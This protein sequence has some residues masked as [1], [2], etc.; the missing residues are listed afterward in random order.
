MCA[1]GWGTEERCL[2]LAKPFSCAFAPLLLTRTLPPLLLPAKTS[3]DIGLLESICDLLAS[4]GY[5]PDIDAVLSF[6]DKCSSMMGDDIRRTTAII[7]SRL[8]A[9]AYRFSPSASLKGTQ[10]TLHGKG[11]EEVRES[12]MMLFET[13][14]DLR[15][16]IHSIDAN[17]GDISNR[18]IDLIGEGLRR[19][20]L[21][22]DLSWNL[23][24]CY[25]HLRNVHAVNVVL[26]SSSHRGDIDR[27]FAAFS[28][29]KNWVDLDVKSCNYLL[30]AIVS[31][32]YGGGEDAERVVHM[33]NEEGI[34]LNK[35]SW[36]FLIESHLND[37]A[38]HDG[39]IKGYMVLKGLIQRQEVV[40]EQTM[41]RVCR[42]LAKAGCHA[43]AMEVEQW[44]LDKYGDVPEYLRMRIARG[45]Q[46]AGVEEVESEE[47]GGDPR[48]SFSGSTEEGN[49]DDNE[50]EEEEEEEDKTEATNVI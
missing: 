49:D 47:L 11:E 29:A 6:D 36:G 28:E 50:E 23:L 17:G 31:R 10:Y 25:P 33:M 41:V 32:G 2:T 5:L 4:S 30:K 24:E 46:G 22:V 16:S 8:H 45:R 14:N 43:E 42:E 39:V 9:M 37:F 19:K 13:L 40:G 15:N 20:L 38:D 1:R 35:E 27:T 44:M 12:I 48:G 21:Y 18:L 3:Q 7:E 34:E 26:H